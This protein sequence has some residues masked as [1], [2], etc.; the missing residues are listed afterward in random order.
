MSTKR[1]RNSLGPWATALDAQPR[2]AL[3]TF[4]QRRMAM[5]PRLSQTESGVTGVRRLALGLLGLA[6]LLAPLVYLTR[7]APLEADDLP[8]ELVQV[9]AAPAQEF[10]PPLSE[11]E[12]RITAEL[13]KPTTFEFTET[14]L[15]DVVDYLRN[16]HEIQI[17]FDE[18]ALEDAGIENQ[19]SIT[20]VLKGVS[21]RSAL[22]RILSNLDMTY[23]VDDDMLLITTKEAASETLITRTYPVGDLMADGETKGLAAAITESVRPI[24]WTDEGGLGTVAPVKAAKSLVV[25]QTHEVHDEIVKLLRSLRA[26]RKAADADTK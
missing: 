18:K 12:K 3:D 2:A 25:S 26:A 11:S 10:L 4:W 6:A 21:L 7:S 15:A 1:S 9:G 19:V 5:L 20:R 16:L 17:Q 14:P 8:G 24:S 23:I 22:R 13:D